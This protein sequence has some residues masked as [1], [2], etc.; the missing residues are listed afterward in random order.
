M[1]EKFNDEVVRQHIQ[2]ILQDTPYACSLEKLS[3][4]SAN[5]VYRGTLVSPLPD[6][7]K[8]IVLKHTEGYSASS[9][10][11]KISKVRGVSEPSTE[12][13][14]SSSLTNPVIAL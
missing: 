1:V 2:Q 3:G 10:D 13:E 7:A 5:Y 14:F 12:P 4:G 8:T 6:G 11:F 9:P